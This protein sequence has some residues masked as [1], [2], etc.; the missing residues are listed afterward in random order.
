[1]VRVHA[2]VDTV[3]RWVAPAWGAIEQETTRTTIVHA[4]AESYESIA[5]WLLLLQ[6]DIEVLEPNELRTAFVHVAQQA[7]RAAQPG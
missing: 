4:G 3:Q 7:A 2:T 5:R 1:M 6:A